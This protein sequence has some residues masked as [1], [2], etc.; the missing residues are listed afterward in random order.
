MAKFYSDAVIASASWA[1]FERLAMRLLTLKGFSQ[2]SVVGQTGD[3]GA[4]VL[5]LHNGH[6]WL[7]Q[8]KALKNPVAGTVVTETLSAMSKYGASIPVIMS[9]NGF[10][11]DVRKRQI[12]LTQHGIRMQLWDPLQIQKLGDL[13]P[14]APAI[15]REP[16]NFSLRD[17]QKK[18]IEN[19]VAAYLRDRSSSALVV[20][21]TGLG[22]TFV[23]AEAIRRMRQGSQR[24]L[25]LA[26]TVDLVL[27]LEKAF[28]PF[29]ATTDA[30]CVVTSKDRPKYWSDLENYQYVFAT[31]DS[32]D[33]LQQQGVELP[34]FDFVVVDECH[35]LGAEVYERVLDYLHVGE[36]DGPF[37]LG[38]TA[39]PWRPGG[40]KLDHRFDEPVVSVDL[41]RGLADGYL[42]NVDYR[43]YTGNVRWESLKTLSGETFSPSAINRTLFIN[44]WDD[45]VV[46]QVYEAWKELGPKARG[47]VFCGTIDHAKSMEA[48]INAMGFTTAKAIYSGGTE[49]NPSISTVERNRM[50]WD[51]SDGRIGIICAVD[52]LN[53]GVD[54]P[55]VN[56]VVFQR[57]THSRRIFTQ[58][59]GR[60]LRLAP[61]KD[62]VIVLDFVSDI[63]RFAAGLQLERDL[64][65]AANTKG[66]RRVTLNSSVTFHKAGGQDVVGQAFLQEWLSDLD[67]VEAAGEDVSVLNFPPALDTVIGNT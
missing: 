43:M 23:A 46:N 15:E 49:N 66:T 18:G 40:E 34:K 41:A 33:S 27:Q 3:G 8:V 39:T 14:E 57:V 37:L 19:I 32:L 48:R 44:E 12:E 60:G 51:F 11:Q 21:A 45:G 25:V 65:K 36:A 10:T 13:L 62:K 22:K 20:L 30:T 56:L 31:R 55:D 59:L 38:L 7:V 64:N 28:W 17:Y 24:V 9:K 53:E 54:V 58:Q 61:D 29:M 5:G 63:R 42:A 47:I 4:D 16:E 50:L 52:I 26:H 67:E 1:A 2:C 35:H 6:R